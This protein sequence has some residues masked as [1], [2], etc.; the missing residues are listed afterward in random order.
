MAKRDNT[1]IWVVGGAAALWWLSGR[2]GAGTPVNGG[3]VPEP[4]ARAN[5]EYGYANVGGS[6]GGI[7]SITLAQ[8][9][10]Y[11][12]GTV[13]GSVAW[14]AQTTNSNGIP[15]SWPYKLIVRLEHLTWGALTVAQ[16]WDSYTVT[17]SDQSNGDVLSNFTLK[18]PEGTKQGDLGQIRVEL[19]GARS[20]SSGNS[21]SGDYTSLAKGEK[22]NAIIVMN[23]D[24]YAHPGG[25]I[26]DIT[27]MKG[28]AMKNLRLRQARPPGGYENGIG[29]DRQWP[30]Y[31]D[32]LSLP[33]VKILVR[34]KQPTFGD[35]SHVGY[36][37]RMTVV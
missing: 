35:V 24:V 17:R 9:P 6:V 11:P 4:W 1:L 19:T 25:M 5:G 23:P 22:E 37:R 33:G 34:Q 18:I 2:T 7:D 28:T 27:L 29:E 12:G 16:E 14:R 30:M 10:Y 32:N 8:K 31:G 26:G 13:T 21:I 3:D 36:G 20:D 15:I